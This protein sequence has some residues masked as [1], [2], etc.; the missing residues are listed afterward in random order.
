MRFRALSLLSILT[1]LIFASCNKDDDDGPKL[2]ASEQ[3]AVDVK[4]IEDYLTANGLEA[5][6]TAS[7]LHYIIL[8]EGSGEHPNI[9]HTVEV[10]YKGY[11]TDGFV[12]DET[13]PAATLIYPLRN[14]IPGWQEGIPFLKSGGGQGVLLI[15]SRLAYG[16]TG[17]GS[18]I[19]PNTVIIFD[20]TLLD[21]E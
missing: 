17:S 9:D 6:R 12:F 4:I 5:T 2:S 10:K 21:F 19:P 14:L 11:R 18:D 1:I 3:L 7:G 16:S 13:A 20:I 15:P 8:E